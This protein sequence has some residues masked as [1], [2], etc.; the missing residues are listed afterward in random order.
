MRR[1]QAWAAWTSVLGALPGGAA[2]ASPE[3]QVPAPASSEDGLPDVFRGVVTRDEFIRYLDFQ[4]Q[5]E[6]S[7]SLRILED[8]ELQL[9]RELAAVRS[10]RERLRE[11]LLGRHGVGDIERRLHAALERDRR[12]PR[13]EPEAAP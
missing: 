3:A 5:L 7:A 1:W 12:R 6:S 8:R 13:N 11:D 9:V 10:E 2:P 4:D